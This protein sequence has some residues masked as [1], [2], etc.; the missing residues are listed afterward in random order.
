MKKL[1]TLTETEKTGALVVPIVALGYASLVA[2][3]A[4]KIDLMAS[5]TIG[6]LLVAFGAISSGVI[7]GMMKDEQLAR[8]VRGSRYTLNAIT[9]ERDELSDKLESALA[10]LRDEVARVRTLSAQVMADAEQLDDLRAH[11]ETLGNKCVNY[12]IQ[13]NRAVNAVDELRNELESVESQLNDSHSRETE[14]RTANRALVADLAWARE[15]LARDGRDLVEHDEADAYA[16]TAFTHS[17]STALLVGTLDR[18]YVVN[19]ETRYP[20]A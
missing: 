5:M 2:L 13:R 18:A 10:D 9:A 1:H 7:V 4:H 16:D 17:A 12:Q 19:G 20:L 3:M 8:V 15:L 11:N 14:L 6:A